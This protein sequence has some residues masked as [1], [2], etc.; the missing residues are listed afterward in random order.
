MSIPAGLPEPRPDQQYQ[1]SGAAMAPGSQT[2]VVRARQVIIFGP[3]GP[4]VGLF[5]YAV[6]TTPGPGNPPVDSITRS[7][8]DPFG[9]SGLPN[10]FVA[11]GSGGAYV[12][13]TSGE[14]NF[15]GS[16]G[17]ASP[18]QVRTENLAGF[19]DLISGQVGGGDAEAEVTLQSAS[20][21]GIGKS[22]ILLNADQI[23]GIL[24]IPSATDPGPVTAAPAAYTQAWGTNIVTVL[25]TIIAKGGQ[26]GLWP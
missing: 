10:D 11:Y 3:S 19:L 13:M 9:N 1:T 14:L 16:S 18:A 20:A 25:N 24:N 4:V 7:G 21:S 23:G 5:V 8:S 2:P 26:I 15:V 22:Q 6:G 17:Q 12:Q